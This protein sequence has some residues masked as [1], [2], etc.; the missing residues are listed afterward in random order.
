MKIY[1]IGD[2]C[3]G[4]T[5]FLNKFSD[6]RFEKFPEE[7]YLKIPPLLEENKFYSFLWFYLY[8]YNRERSVKTKKI[9]I[10]ERGLHEDYALLKACFCTGKINR[11]QREVMKYVIDSMMKDIPV[12]KNDLAVNFI[13]QN[14]IIRKRLERRGKKQGPEKEKYWSICRNELKKFYLDKCNYWQIET[15]YL[16]Q[17]EVFKAVKNK[18]YEHCGF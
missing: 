17:K 13:C 8:Y 14:E 9:P 11:K 1:I 4:K 6:S 3:A 5:V 15:S 10:I 18:I 12:Q 2:P 16:D 7:G